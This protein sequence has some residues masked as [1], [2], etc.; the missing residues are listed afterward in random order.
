MRGIAT[1][2]VL[3]G[4]GPYYAID[5]I[6]VDFV[7]TI[8]LNAQRCVLPHPILQLIFAAALPICHCWEEKD[9]F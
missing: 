5:S 1:A 6:E 9:T 8:V 4:Q 3:P 7:V 2:D